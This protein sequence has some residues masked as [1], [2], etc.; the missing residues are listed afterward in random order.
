METPACLSP[1]RTVPNSTPGPGLCDMR[2]HGLHQP[3]GRVLY[4]KVAAAGA[5]RVAGR[6]RGVEHGDRRAGRGVAADGDRLAG[7]ATARRVWPGW[8]TSR[9]RGGRGTIDHRADRGGDVDAAAEEARGHALVDAGCWPG[10][11]GSA[12]P[13][14][15][16]RGG[17]TGSSRGGRRRSSSPP[18]RSWSPRSPTSSGCTWPRRRTRSCCAW[19]RSPRSR[20]WTGPRRCCRCSPGWPNAAPT[21]TS[22]TAPRPCSRRWRS[23][24]GRSP[25]RCKPRHRHQEFLR[26]PQAGRPGLPRAGELHLVMDNYAAHKHP[27]V[28]DW[29]AANPRVHVHFTPTSASWMNLVE[30]W[31]G[32]IERQAIH[33]GTFGSVTRPQRQDPRLHQRLERPL[34]TPSSGPRPPTRSSRKPTVQTTSNTGH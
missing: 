22:G 1:Q 15:P 25:R 5:D 14:W 19:T 26:V 3:W 18:T 2:G 32:I 4:V 12:T 28:R 23:P 13:R 34:P 7:P 9:G 31:F 10:I 16:G 33:R 27:E 21:T 8:T 6:G 20:R 24:P 30:V 29:L 11:W 17:S